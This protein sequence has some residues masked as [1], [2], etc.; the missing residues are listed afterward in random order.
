MSG[1]SFQVATGCVG[2]CRQLD[3][4]YFIVWTVVS[5]LLRYKLSIVPLI[6]WQLSLPLL[7]TSLTPLPT[8]W[9]SPNRMT[10]R[11]LPRWM[12][13][14]MWIH[15]PHSIFLKQIFFFFCLSLQ[16]R[17]SW[18]SHGV[19][20]TNLIHQVQIKEKFYWCLVN[21]ISFLTSAPQPN[22]SSTS[23]LV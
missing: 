2:S 1:P 23:L 13:V 12:Y 10:L 8:A 9:W 11:N 18:N 22:E 15:L 5:S 7:I 17:L 3:S 21:L 20:I 14:W 6:Y 19:E 16:P 4:R